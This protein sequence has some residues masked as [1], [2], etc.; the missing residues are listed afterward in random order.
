MA[1]QFSD[2]HIEE[3]LTQG[4]T[5]FRGIVPPA[6]VQDLRGET[7]RGR[8]QIRTTRGPQAQR[9]QPITSVDVDAAPFAAFR[10]LPELNDA[11][12]RTLSPHHSYG[13]PSQMGVLLEPRDH[14]YCIRWH[15]DGRD[16]QPLLVLEQ[17]E[18]KFG[19][20]DFF[21]QS[22]CALYDDH[23][24]WVVPGSHLR[25]DLPRER[26]R[27][28]TRPIMPPVLDGLGE[29]ER[30]RVCLAYC[31]SMPGAVQICLEPGDYTLYRSVLWHAGNYVPY[32]RRATLHDYVD[33]PAFRQW[34]TEQRAVVAGLR[35]AGRAEWD[36]SVPRWGPVKPVV[37]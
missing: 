35:A 29:P 24:L 11:V 30:E 4:F 9:F 10:E 32:T 6:L 14:A 19:N 26:A 18:E 36:W 1:F 20:L 27:F 31:R 13:D 21:G 12:H 25:D 34:R 23:S 28:P 7:D 33:T 16:N 17:W 5:V 15:R 22:N 8:E 2:R 3:F 37:G